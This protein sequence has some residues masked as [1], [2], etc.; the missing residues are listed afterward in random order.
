MRPCT[1]ALLGA[2]GLGGCS[3]AVPLPP[4]ALALNQSGAR[5]LESGDLEAADARLTVALEYSPHFVEALVNLGLVELQRGNFARA[6]QLL[7]R[8]RRLN[9]DV[10]QPHHALGVLAE[11]ERRPDRASV[12]YREALAVDPGFLPARANLS[13]LLFNAGHLEAALL[14]FRRLMEIAP[15]NP[16]GTTGVI[17]SLIRLGR[18]GEAEALTSSAIERF[19]TSH[20]VRVLAARQRLRRGDVKRAIALLLPLSRGSDDAAATALAWIATAE[21]LRG[22]PRHAVGAADRALALDPEQPVARNAM[23]RA[24]DQLDDPGAQAWQPRAR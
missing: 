15:E 19:S 9:P 21:L 24:L 2:A 18:F 4:R 8:A 20:E 11:R 23:A 22:R 10:A 13:R 1:L 7:E 17:E 6:R 12:H 3:T 14:S 5:A 16:E